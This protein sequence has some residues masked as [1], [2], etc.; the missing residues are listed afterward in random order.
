MKGLKKLAA[1]A[2]VVGV[3]GTGFAAYAST[4]TTPVDIAS[5]LTGKTVEELSQERVSGKTYGTIAKE[6]GKLEEFKTE[7]LEQ[8]KAVLEQ[9]VKDGL[10]TQEQAD[11]II[12]AITDNQV[13]CDG[14]GSSMVG[15]KF[16]VG[17]GQGSG[18]GKGMGNGACGS[19]EVN[20]TTN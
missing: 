17:F 1:V 19:C 8:K 18:M 7:M 12:K 3:I 2:A 16:G 5:K 20:T 11:E 14:S 9:R 15:K 13:N 6:A 10:L 4:G